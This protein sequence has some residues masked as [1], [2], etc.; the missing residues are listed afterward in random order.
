MLDK[1]DLNQSIDINKYRQELKVLENRLAMLQQP[2][3]D[4]GIPIL[5][6]FEG[7]SASGK[8]TLIKRILYPLDP[9]QFNVHTMGKVTEDWA[10][11]PFLWPYWAR[12]P[13]KGRF[14]IVDKSWHR[15]I[16]PDYSEKWRL[17]PKVK[18]EFF[19][20]VNAFERQLLDDGVIILKF[21]LH[22]SKEA[23]RV[24]F[25]DLEKNPGTAWRVREHDWEQNRNYGSYLKA[26]DEMLRKTDYSNSKWYI[27]EANDSKFATIKSLSIITERVEAE[28]RRLS[29]VEAGSLWPDPPAE[30]FPGAGILSAVDLNKAIKDK[31]YKERLEKL[32]ARISE[33]GFR[34]YKARRS[35]VI[36]YEGWDA[37]GKGGN[38]KRLTESLDPR[39]YEVI[40][41]GAP[42]AAELDHHYLWR[43][44]NKMPKDG[45]MAIFDRSWYGRVMVESVER[46]TPPERIQSAYQEI[47]D[48]E[49]HLANHGSIILKF[50][51]HIDIDKQLERFEDRQN[52][53]AKQYKITDEDWRNREKWDQYEYAVDK[54]LHKTDTKYAPWIIIESNDKKYAR[55]KVLEIVVTE[56]E[57]QLG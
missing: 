18:Q 11:R 38:I 37:A 3:K 5:I 34:L 52:D 6:V 46:L 9:R 57:K 41:I 40:P 45:H 10:M 32:Q 7:W 8:G 15:V 42:S 31:E 55:I 54:M 26:Y 24:R 30:E 50:W 17:S 20:D 29:Y 13:A 49:R 16:L 2:I 56:L 21:F 23:Q 44:M 22:I 25:K 48:M 28:V 39:A 36:V 14:S 4:L 19:Y 12:T 33:L 47:N 51:L 43:F 1:I 27:I 35:V 53:P